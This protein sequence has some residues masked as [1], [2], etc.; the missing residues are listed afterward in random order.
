MITLF[1]FNAN[2]RD[3]V[4]EEADE[5]TNCYTYVIMCTRI[6]LLE[7]ND[8]AHKNQ[9]PIQNQ[10]FLLLTKNY[11]L[12]FPLSPLQISLQK[13]QLVRK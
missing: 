8:N 11:W 9:E 7:E 5:V 2:W 6:I 1:S 4:K 10:N 12:T 3:S 13:N